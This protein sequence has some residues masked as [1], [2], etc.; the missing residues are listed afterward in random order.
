MDVIKS[1]DFYKKETYSVSKYF[2]V[3]TYLDLAIHVDTEHRDLSRATDSF[4]IRRV[5]F[6]D[7][8]GFMVCI[9]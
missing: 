4:R 7:K 1:I 2:S 5:T 9:I 6:Q 3:P 8:A